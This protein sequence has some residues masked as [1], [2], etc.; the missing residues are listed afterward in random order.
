MKTNKKSD[1]NKPEKLFLYCL[2][3]SPTPMTIGEI[4]DAVSE[5]N[6]PYR[7]N[8]VYEVKKR[9]FHDSPYLPGD[10]VF[11]EDDFLTKQSDEFILEPLR[12]RNKIFK[13]YKNYFK[14]EN[15]DDLNFET[16]KKKDEHQNEIKCIQ[17]TDKKNNY[18]R[19]EINFTRL[20][21]TKKLEKDQI[22]IFQKSRF[23]NIEIEPYFHVRREKGTRLV[24]RNYKLIPNFSYHDYID[25]LRSS[26]DEAKYVLN[27]KGL[28]H[29]FLLYKGRLDMASIEKIISNVSNLDEYMNLSDEIDTAYSSITSIKK[30][31][32]E[33]YAI[34][35]IFG[36]NSPFK[37]KRRFPFLSFYN[38]YKDYIHKY[39]ESFVSD[40]LF[41]VALE[42][43][44]QLRNM[45]ITKLKY[46]VTKRYLE[47][48]RRYFYSFH[49]Q[50]LVHVNL[51]DDTFEAI[52]RLQDEIGVYIEEMKRSDYEWEK[53]ERQRYE[54]ECTDID[55]KRKLNTLT[56]SNSSVISLK[57]ILQDNGDDGVIVNTSQRKMIERFCKYGEEEN[58]SYSLINDYILIKN[59]L[60]KE[61]S[62]NIDPDNFANDLQSELH[63]N[64]IPL[65]CKKDI[66]KWINNY[67]K[68]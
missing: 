34:T 23:A 11:T 12:F 1:K 59:S 65:D 53:Q 46:E 33:H 63:K 17:V 2:G 41:T 61:I 51:S 45:S 67:L 16:P 31:D 9:L 43:E 37:I 56:N 40:F 14:C 48:I 66:K 15:I 50:R 20:T 47:K 52:T 6:R 4:E 26:E 54:K 8:Y 3:M 7:Q 35:K 27:L 39:N 58:D 30:I 62:K 21:E 22:R 36:S 42:F 55:F 24:I 64:G 32:E 10:I 44:L 25:R 28:L 5:K 18:L 19:I 13:E 60:L 38:G 49:S 57:S 29:L 68:L